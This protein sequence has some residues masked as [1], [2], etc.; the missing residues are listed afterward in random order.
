[1]SAIR[2]RLLPTLATLLLCLH[3][4][5]ARRLEPQAVLQ[6]I[7]ETVR[8]WQNWSPELKS[9]EPCTEA[10]P[11]GAAP[12]RVR[13]L[14]RHT[15]TLW[16]WLTVAETLHLNWD[17]VNPD[18]LADTGMGS[19]AADDVWRRNAS[20][21]CGPDSDVLVYCDSVVDARP[22]LQNGCDKP[23]ILV[24]TNRFDWQVSDPSAFLATLKAA[25]GNERVWEGLSLPS[26]RHLMLRPVGASVLPPRPLAGDALGRFA[27]TV[28][29]NRR[30]QPD[31]DV[32]LPQLKLLALDTLVKVYDDEYGGPA[33]L[34]Q[35]RGVI[36]LPYQVSLMSLYETMAA[37]GLFVVPS[38]HFYRA[39]RM[40]HRFGMSLLNLMSRAP[41]EGLNWT[42]YVDFYHPTLE[43]GIVYFNSWEHLADLM[44]LPEDNPVWEAKREAG[45]SAMAAVRD[46][47][48]VG[49]RQ[50]LEQAAAAAGC[51]QLVGA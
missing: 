39:L 23:I 38:F 35:H 6:R 18:R 50:V 17:R 13:Y 49:W 14:T 20:A 4:I 11:S 30:R 42:R 45:R 41:R 31:K 48:L 33:T 21:L 5:S 7:G 15:G 34:A 46:E 2:R 27:V 12:A 29:S 10:T 16:D 36:H 3:T 37:G 40:R 24:V 44:R 25:A 1:M 32:L 43:P 47:S 19:R 22:A 26:Q 28:K 9:R 51:P 8:E